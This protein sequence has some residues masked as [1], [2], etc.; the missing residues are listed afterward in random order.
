MYVCPF[1]T[2]LLQID[3]SFLFLDGIEPLFGCHFSMWHSTKCC[4]SIFDLGPQPPN[5]QN[6]LRKICQKIA[7][8]S[9]CMADRPE[10]FGPTRGFSGMA[11]SMEPY[12]M[13]WGRPL[14][15]WQQN[16]GKC[17]LFLHKIAYKSACMPHRADMFGPTRGPTLVAMAKTEI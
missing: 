10:I 6:L 2:L 1:V 11:D 16:F 4:S 8:N 13:L 5:A 7:Y 14:L 17:G 9:A 3:S 15:P 12:K